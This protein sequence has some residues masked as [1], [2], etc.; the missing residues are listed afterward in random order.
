MKMRKKQKVVE[1]SEVEEGAGAEVEEVVA[2]FVVGETSMT[3]MLL[4][5]VEVEEKLMATK[6]R[7]EV[8][9]EEEQEEVEGTEEAETMKMKKMEASGRMIKERLFLL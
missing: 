9:V 2:E 5:A 3:M 8:A 7:E 4:E 1:I 6:V